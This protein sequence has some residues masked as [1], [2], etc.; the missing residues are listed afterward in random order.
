M[1]FPNLP[2]VLVEGEPAELASLLLSLGHGESHRETGPSMPPHP[3][4]P[5]VSNRRDRVISAMGAL[6][7]TGKIILRLDAI[8]DKVGAMFPGEDLQHID[9]VVRDLVN[10]TDLVERCDRGTFRLT[11]SGLQIFEEKYFKT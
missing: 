5:L 3:Q 4:V 1:R 10:K 6:K 8:R 7:Q 9:Q 2:E 11:D